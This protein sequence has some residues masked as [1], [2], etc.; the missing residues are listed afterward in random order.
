M[1]GLVCMKMNKLNNLL[2]SQL[3]LNLSTVSG[4]GEPWRTPLFF[5]FNKT[6]NCF[7]WWSPENSQH[8]KNIK[9][10]PKCFITIFDSHDKEGEGSGIY[11]TAEAEEL[12]LT[13]NI[14]EATELYNKKAKT[15]KLSLS[16]CTGDAP[17]RIYRARMIKSWHNAD[18]YDDNNKFYDV[19]KNLKIQ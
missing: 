19:R 17:T 1:I 9:A 18:A 11:F 15:F 6:E 10:N 8:S 16:D 2:N 3:Y 12:K 5:V 7:Y 4:G 14:Q 13:E